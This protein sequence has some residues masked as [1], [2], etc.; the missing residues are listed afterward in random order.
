M[1]RHTES[2]KISRLEYFGHGALKL[3]RFL[4]YLPR[5]LRDCGN[6]SIV[7][8]SGLM[9]K[10]ITYH[11]ESFFEWENFDE[12]FQMITHFDEV[13]CKFENVNANELIS[14]N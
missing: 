10:K 13:A 12:S 7:S 14:C 8:F 4:C 6:F 1:K 9:K 11:P 2:I 5:R 3:K